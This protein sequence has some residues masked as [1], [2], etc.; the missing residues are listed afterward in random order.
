MNG[1]G[2]NDTGPCR[3]CGLRP[4]PELQRVPLGGAPDPCL[5]LLDGC[6]QACCGHGL[7]SAAYVCIAEGVAPGTSCAVVEH[8]TLR[9]ADAVAWF[10]ANLAKDSRK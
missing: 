1:Q 2:T 7:E 5:G 10:Q 8:R 4:D 6:F 9:G 3:A